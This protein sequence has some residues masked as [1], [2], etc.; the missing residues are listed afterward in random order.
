MLLDGRPFAVEGVVGESLQHLVLGSAV[1]TALHGG[2]SG[3]RA[4]L[5][6]SALGQ[7]G[8]QALGKHCGSSRSMGLTK[9]EVSLSLA[10]WDF[11]VVV[12]VVD[13]GRVREGT[14]STDSSL[15]IR[16]HTWVM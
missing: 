8:H 3:R 9:G 2:T 6:P 13:E 10:M 12:D 11:L 4:Q 1:E 7:A 16:P 15:V 14:S 5:L